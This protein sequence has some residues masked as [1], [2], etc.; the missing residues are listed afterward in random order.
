M[1]DNI[2]EDAQMKDIENVDYFVKNPLII[3]LHN[4]SMSIPDLSRYLSAFL[5]ANVADYSNRILVS[6]SVW[7]KY[8]LENVL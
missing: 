4:K 8:E 7:T 1:E 5:S 2:H 6:L 3:C